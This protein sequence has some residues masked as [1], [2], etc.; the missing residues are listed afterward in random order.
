LG[1][2]TAATHTLM[3]IERWL[4]LSGGILIVL[5]LVAYRFAA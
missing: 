4:W 5:G 2:W 1:G 3:A